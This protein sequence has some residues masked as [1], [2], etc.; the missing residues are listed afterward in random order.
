MCAGFCVSAETFYWTGPTGGA[1]N[2]ADNWALVDG[3]VSGCPV[4]G[5][6]AVFTNDFAL[7]V[8]K[9]ERLSWLQYV[10]KG[11]SVNFTPNTDRFQLYGGGS[12]SVSSGGT[13]TFNHA[14]EAN[15]SYDSTAFTKDN[16]EFVFDVG[17]GATV[18]QATTGSLKISSPALVVKRGAGQLNVTSV[19]N[20]G[21]P[22]IRLEEGEFY[23]STANTAKKH[24]LSILQVVGPEQ[25]RVTYYGAA[26][27]VSSYVESADSMGTLTLAM[28]GNTRA[29]TFNATEDTRFSADVV[30]VSAGATQYHSFIWNPSDECTITVVGRVYNQPKTSFT[31]NAGMMRFAEGAGVKSLRLITVKSGA[32]LAIAEDAAW[33]FSGAPVELESAT[34]KLNIESRLT[35]FRPRSLKVA[36]SEIPEG[37]YRASDFTWLTGEGILQVGSPEATYATWTANGG[38]DCSILNPANWGAADNT[39][40]PDLTGGSLVATFANG[41]RATVPSGNTDCY[42]KGLVFSVG[43]DFTI[44]GSPNSSMMIGETGIVAD[45]ASDGVA[46]RID[47]PTVLACDQDWKLPEKATDG[48]FSLGE[49]GVVS[50]VRSVT[51]SATGSLY[52]YST[53]PDFCNLTTTGSIYPHADRPLG[54]SSVTTLLRGEGKYLHLYG[55]SFYNNFSSAQSSTVFSAGAMLNLIEGVNKFYGKVSSGGPNIVFWYAAN[56][57]A[58]K[59]GKIEFHGGL[60]HLST[61]QGAMMGPRYQCEVSV[62]DVPMDMTKF[63]MGYYSGVTHYPV[64]LNLNVASNLTTRGIMG[65]AAGARINTTVPYALYATDT[66]ASGIGFVN[67]GVWDLCGCDQAVNNFWA[68]SDLVRVISENPAVLHIR[69]DRLNKVYVHA[70]ATELDPN[71]TTC[72]VRVDRAKY[73]GAVSLS[74]EGVMDRW[75]IAESTSTGSVSVTA[76]KLIFARKSDGPVT[77]S[78]EGK[79]AYTFTPTTGSWRDAERISISGTGILELQHAAAFDRKVRISVSGSNEGR[80]VIPEGVTVKCEELRINGVAVGPCEMSDGLVTGGGKLRVGHFGLIM[81]VK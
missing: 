33:D 11:A 1:A 15:N 39:Q 26:L 13:Y 9:T 7:S 17:I 80:I 71:L 35:C 2:V 22:A 48:T 3:S 21:R 31:V 29:T 8:K 37:V 46:Y 77:I 69:D 32:T 57:A 30:N 73:E 20:S 53:N 58:S 40:L 67:S 81:I 5:D 72:K 24:T 68:G 61:V 50:A 43:G 23:L 54:G 45:A 12:I 18:K 6:T 70:T 28:D 47:C 63:I 49:K 74:K 66:G 44:E 56:T 75:M 60:T 38:E 52:I 41:S 59:A 19:D 36:G 27:D 65:Y 55:N 4:K 62:A 34:A 51:I 76:G 14:L 42:F 10:F 25:K 79:L 16:N 78:E 64:T